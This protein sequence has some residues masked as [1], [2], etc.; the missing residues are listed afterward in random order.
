MPFLTEA[1]SSDV[2]VSLNMGVTPTHCKPLCKPLS[3]K[4]GLLSPLYPRLLGVSA[5]FAGL[6]HSAPCPLLAWQLPPKVCKLLEGR[7]L[8]RGSSLLSSIVCWQR[9]AWCLAPRE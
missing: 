9:W 8:A 7:G 2:G 4:K 1:V 5:V 6:H 3:S